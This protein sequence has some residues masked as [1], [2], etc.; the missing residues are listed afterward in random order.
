[1]T[2]ILE[3]RD[4]WPLLNAKHLSSLDQAARSHRS[5]HDRCVT[6]IY[7]HL[8]LIESVF[9]S[10]L[11]HSCKIPRDSPQGFGNLYIRNLQH[12]SS[13]VSEWKHELKP[14]FHMQTSSC[15]PPVY[16]DSWSILSPNLVCLET[17][18]SRSHPNRVLFCK[19]C[20]TDISK[21]V[22]WHLAWY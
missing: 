4:N 3:N 21:G 7:W 16:L 6:T 20:W 2:L 22:P 1:M 12:T 5:I 19:I 11:P 8:T 10:C 13:L 14:I 18:I 15:F 9:V 17:R